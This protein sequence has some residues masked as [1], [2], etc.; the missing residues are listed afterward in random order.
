MDDRIK[1]LRAVLDE[2]AREIKPSV[3]TQAMMA[4]TIVVRAAK[5][6]TREELMAAALQA[7]KTPAA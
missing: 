2:A 1:M 6:A 4:E 3:A 7:G 5:G